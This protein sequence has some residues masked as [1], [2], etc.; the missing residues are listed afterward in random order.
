MS[1][2][3]GRGLLGMQ[4]WSLPRRTRASD[5]D[6]HVGDK[7]QVEP[8]E[9]WQG[10]Q[11]TERRGTA[12]RPRPAGVKLCGV[13]GPVGWTQSHGSVHLPWRAAA[14]RAPVAC[15]VVSVLGF[16]LTFLLKLDPAS[17]S[18]LV[19][20][21]CDRPCSPGCPARGHAPFLL[22]DPR[23]PGGLPSSSVLAPT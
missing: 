8:R 12:R 4:T 14:T 2:R 6:G 11:G 13:S 15:A 22:H 1:R 5:G 3:R 18:S 17:D 16:C 21:A 23:S 19:R 10:A 20:W 9:P 7:L